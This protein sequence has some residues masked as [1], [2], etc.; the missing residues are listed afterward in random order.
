MAIAAGVN[1]QIDF[2]NPPLY[3]YLVKPG[4]NSMSDIWIGYY[5]TFYQNLISY[6]TQFG[7]LLPQLTTDQRDSIV[8]PIGGQIIYNTTTNLPQ[9]F[10]I[11]S[12]SPLVGDWKTFV[13][14]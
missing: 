13:L 9:V 4:N 11:T 12:L 8:R 14:V 7:I 6:L 3:D 10:V 2:D 1:S 5:S